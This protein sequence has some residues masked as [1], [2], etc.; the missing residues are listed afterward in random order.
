LEVVREFFQKL[1]VRALIPK[2]M[3]VEG[4]PHNISLGNV[5]GHY[6]LPE[7]I[8]GIEF[9]FKGD[10]HPAVGDALGTTSVSSAVPVR[11]P[12]GNM[13]ALD[14]VESLLHLDPGVGVV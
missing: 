6:D 1:H 12:V 10:P 7:A 3:V 11:I 9:D 14:A 5:P 13:P 2:G 4:L 8:L